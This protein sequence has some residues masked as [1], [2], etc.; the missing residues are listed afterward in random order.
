MNNHTQLSIVIPA[1]NEE[2]AIGPVLERLRSLYPEAEILVVNDGSTD[3][4]ERVATEAGARVLTQPYSMGQWRGDQARRPLGAWRDPGVHGRRRSARPSRHPAATRTARETATTWSSAHA[5]PRRKQG[6]G[7]WVANGLYNRLASLMTGHRIDDLTSGFRAVRARAVSR[8]SIAAAQ[9]LLLSDHH[10]HGLLPVRLPGD[11]CPDP[12]RPPR[13]QESYPAVD[14]RRSASCSSCSRSP[15]S[16]HR[17]RSSCPSARP[18][19]SCWAGLLQLHLR[20]LCALHQHERTC[21]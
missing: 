16:T 7:R 5:M 17:S 11:L 6:S 2:K 4:T 21:S 19:S 8:L 20:S 3:E 13:R 14:G 18:S 10:H 12:R 15:R 9:H 1:K